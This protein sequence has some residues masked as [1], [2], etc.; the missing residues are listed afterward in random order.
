MW[1]LSRFVRAGSLAVIL[2]NGCTLLVPGPGDL[3]RGGDGGLDAETSLAAL[4]L[5]PARVELGEVVVGAMSAPATLTARNVGSAPTNLLSTTLLGASASAFEITDDQ[6][7]GVA[8]LP[9]ESCD[10]TVV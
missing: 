1:P 3:R 5:L 10:I 4:E 9:D 8:L 6:C 7:A 2:L